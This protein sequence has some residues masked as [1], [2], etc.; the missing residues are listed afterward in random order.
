MARADTQQ[1]NH[2]RGNINSTGSKVSETGSPK[3]QELCVK[4]LGVS[5]GP[6]FSRRDTSV[7]SR[8]HR[9]LSILTSAKLD[10]AGGSF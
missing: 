6:G 2:C 7:S 9:A 8:R 5:G 3:P 1:D 10:T 4:E